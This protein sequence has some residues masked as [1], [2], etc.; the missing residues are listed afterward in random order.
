M[1]TKII[2]VYL[3]LTLGLSIDDK[4][5]DR[6][7][8]SQRNKRAKNRDHRYDGSVKSRFMYGSG[9]RAGLSNATTSTIQGRD[10]SRADGMQIPSA[11]TGLLGT[12]A[13]EN[14]IAE[15]A[16][17]ENQGLIEYLKRAAG[18]NQSQSAP[19][20]PPAGTDGD[21][22]YRAAAMYG[23][24]LYEAF[25][26]Y[27]PGYKSEENEQ[28]AN[29]RQAQITR[30]GTPSEKVVIGGLV[31][32]SKPIRGLNPYH[33]YNVEQLAKQK[34]FF[35]ESFEGH[36]W[37]WWYDNYFM[38]FMRV[39]PFLFYAQ[40][41]YYPPLYYDFFDIVGEYPKPIENFDLYVAKSRPW[42]TAESLPSSDEKTHAG[43]LNSYFKD[44]FKGWFTT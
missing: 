39:F 13:R 9:T 1:K 5:P 7:E 42:P 23:P 4:S 30:S 40:Y 10:L 14:Q 2:F 19:A 15:V 25:K 37:G 35:E 26:K 29:A 41:K 44:M 38:Y 17:S 3:M 8:R 11:Q 16:P 6:Y 12:T 28:N 22:L 34:A 20:Q 18:M 24:A 33:P 43:G 21:S 27:I 31:Q 32:P 36:S